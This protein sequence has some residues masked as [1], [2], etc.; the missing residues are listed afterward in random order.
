MLALAKRL[1]RAPF[2][3]WEG[4]SF[5]CFSVF[6]LGRDAHHNI[7]RAAW[8]IFSPDN[9]AVGDGLVIWI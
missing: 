4:W 8:S 5:F 2:L 6:L 7:H 3:R 9:R 1:C